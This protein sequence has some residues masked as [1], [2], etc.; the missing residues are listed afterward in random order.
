MSIVTSR[1]LLKH[2]NEALDDLGG[3]SSTFW[4]VL[5]Q[6]AF[7]MPGVCSVIAKSCPV[8]SVRRGDLVVKRY[9]ENNDT[10]STLLWVELSCHSR[11]VEEVEQRALDAAKRCIRKNNLTWI[12]AMTTVGVSFRIWFVSRKKLQL[13]PMHGSATK[14]DKSQYIDADSDE[15][16]V[17]SKAVQRI[18]EEMIPFRLSPVDLSQLLN[19]STFSHVGQ[20]NSQ[21]SYKYKVAEAGPYR[22][23]L[24]S[25]S[26]DGNSS[27]GYSSDCYSSDGYS[28]DGYSSDG[29]SCRYVEVR[30]EKATH[31]F[32]ADEFIFCNIKGTRKSTRKEDWR[33]RNYQGD[34][35][36]IFRG[37]KNVYFTRKKI[38]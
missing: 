26:S 3:M 33:Y 18:K 11:N 32:S 1:Y 38:A 30:V 5:L 8:K 22:V 28:S 14:A 21:Y 37:K 4:Q 35:V 31:T 17:F 6:Q 27:Y 15:A 2:Y 23:S 36:W 34:K 9:D 12:W 10:L 7:H 19:R 25:D 20:G 24:S 16:I 29:Y 13:E